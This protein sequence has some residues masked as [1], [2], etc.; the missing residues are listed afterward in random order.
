[1]S[2]LVF[3]CEMRT[4]KLKIFSKSVSSTHKIPGDNTENV[5]EHNDKSAR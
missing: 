5:R 2:P 3:D 4:T 1:M